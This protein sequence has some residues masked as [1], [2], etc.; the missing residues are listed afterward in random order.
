MVCGEIQRIRLPRG[1]D[2]LPKGTAFVQFSTDEEVQR[3]LELD[4]Q[5][6]FGEGNSIS[7]HRVNDKRPREGRGPK[8]K[9]DDSTVAYVQYKSDDAM[10]RALEWN[11]T[12]HLGI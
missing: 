5:E 1:S 12:W 7:V 3:A 11:N 9:N 4:Q 8:E 10:N 6:I 2:G